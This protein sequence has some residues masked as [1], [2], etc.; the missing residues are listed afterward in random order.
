MI[1]K[2]ISIAAYVLTVVAVILLLAAFIPPSW[3]VVYRPNMADQRWHGLWSQKKCDSDGDCKTIATGFEIEGGREWSLLVLLYRQDLPPSGAGAGGPGTA[4]THC[5]SVRKSRLRQV[6]I[7]TLGAAGLFLLLSAIIFAAMVGRLR[8][9]GS[10]S[11][12]LGPCF[13][14][15]LLAAIVSLTASAMTA[16]ASVRK[17]NNADDD[18]DEAPMMMKSDQ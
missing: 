2:P 1:I 10:Q 18:M 11:V 13:P 17:A 12:D 14:L 4:T 6:V 7:Y 3:C 16:W 8:D 9:G 15:S 5:I